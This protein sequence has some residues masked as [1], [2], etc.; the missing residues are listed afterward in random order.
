MNFSAISSMHGW[1][2]PEKAMQLYELT[3]KLKPKVVVEIGVWGGRSTLP[4]AMALRELGAGKLIAIDP[5]SATESEK[6]QTEPQSAA[7]WAAQNHEDVYKSFMWHMKRNA[8]EGIVQVQRTTSDAAS[9]PEEIGLLLLDGNH[10]EQA[11][12]DAKRFAP[13]VVIGGMCLLDDLDWTG[14]H[15]R[16]AEEFIKSIGFSF[17]RLLD[18]GNG[19]PSQTGLYQRAEM[20]DPA[21]VEAVARE[22]EQA[23]Q[24]RIMEEPARLT[25]AYITSRKEPKFEWFIDSLV[26]QMS[27]EDKL[28]VIV[29][30]TFNETRDWKLNP[31]FFEFDNIKLRNVEP[32]PTIWQGKHRITK[33]DW[34]AASNARNTAICLCETEWIAFLDDRCVLLP[35]WLEAVKKAMRENYVVLGSYEKRSKM[36]VEKGFIRGFDSLIGKDP[37]LTQAPQGKKN[38]PHSWMFGCTFA[39]PLAVALEING[40][41]EAADGLSMEDSLFGLMLR[42]AGHQLT[43]DPSMRMIEDRTEGECAPVMK[44]SSKEKHP[45]DVGDKGHAALKR[46]G[47]LKRTEFTPNL[48]AIREDLR[49]GRGFPTHLPESDPVDWFDGQKIR[50]MI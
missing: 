15:V 13:K 36:V 37:R 41:E 25:V 8:L 33:D 20:I 2:T 34:W 26:N 42:N 16:Q 9:V 24:R 3:K 22:A 7:W 50:E 45:N 17:V 49:S 4:M 31:R 6:G 47:I 21:R 5:W 18:E 32:K 46:F 40:F 48:S 10:G 35:G 1:T 19:K 44:R 43:Y 12:I 38:C 28:H 23:E 30:D 11:L 39:M 29:V 27:P 14:G